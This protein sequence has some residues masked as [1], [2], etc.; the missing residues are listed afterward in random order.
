MVTAADPRSLYAIY[1]ISDEYTC[2]VKVKPD[3]SSCSVTP[4]E[5]LGIKRR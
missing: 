3:V 1:I 4:K 2:E 5:L